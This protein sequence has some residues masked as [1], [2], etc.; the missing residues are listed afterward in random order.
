MCW[1]LATEEWRSLAG[2]GLWDSA[3]IFP[4]V[5]VSSLPDLPWSRGH[6]L[7]WG[8]WGQVHPAWP[9]G[10]HVALIESEDP[11]VLIVH[12]VGNILQVLE[13]GAEG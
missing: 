12:I 4:G 3:L 11:I 2:L 8:G 9:S 5:L 7:S 1:G 13:V 6:Q 10:Q